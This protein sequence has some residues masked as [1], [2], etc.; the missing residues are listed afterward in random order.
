MVGKPDLEEQLA[1]PIKEYVVLFGKWTLE[2]P[3]KKNLT[4]ILRETHTHGTTSTMHR[5][6]PNN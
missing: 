1:S 6:R 4:Y 3:K 2:L 5:I